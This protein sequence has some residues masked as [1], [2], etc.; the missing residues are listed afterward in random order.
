MDQPRT[1]H[2]A[3]WPQ[4]HK[5]DYLP[6]LCIIV[7]MRLPLYYKGAYHSDL[8]VQDFWLFL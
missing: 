2:P 4:L 7:L 6:C 5:V 8:R 3:V 1:K